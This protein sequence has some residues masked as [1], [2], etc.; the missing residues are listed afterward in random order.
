MSYTKVIQPVDADY[1]DRK[2]REIIN[3]NNHV[4]EDYI[5]FFLQATGQKIEDLILVQQTREDR[6]HFWL[7]RKDGKPL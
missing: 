2:I 1:V 7:E 3:R 5:K 4:F 6:I